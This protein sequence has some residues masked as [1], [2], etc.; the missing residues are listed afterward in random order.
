MKIKYLEKNGDKIIIQS[1]S[2]KQI[3]SLTFNPNK[4]EWRCNCPHSTFR[5][6]KNCKHIKAFL[7]GE[8]SEPPEN[9]KEDEFS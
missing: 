1:L 5:K 7:D 9:I 4:N 2:S 6:V 3:Y 8:L